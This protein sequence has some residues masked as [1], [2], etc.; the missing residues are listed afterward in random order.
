M[1]VEIPKNAANEP[2]EQTAD[3]KHAAS[4]G[5]T[6]VASKVSETGH[7]E[8]V[9]DGAAEQTVD[10]PGQ[11]EE[12]RSEAAN[13]NLNDKSKDDITRLNLALDN[14]STTIHSDASFFACAENKE[15]SFGK[16]L[17]EIQAFLRNSITTS[18]VGNSCYYVCGVP[19]IGKTSGVLWSV[20]KV[21]KD[22]AAEKCVIAGP[23]DDSED[24]DDVAKPVLCHV[25]A[26]H[27]T[28]V[29][30]TFE[31]IL[32]QIGQVVGVKGKVD[33]I[34]K[35]GKIH[36]IVVMDEIENL[37]AK[38]PKKSFP[39]SESEESLEKLIEMA[40]DDDVH[41][42]LI[43]ISNSVGDEKFAR[44]DG[45][46]AVRHNRRRLR[47]R[48]GYNGSHFSFFCSFARSHLEPIRKMI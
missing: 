47:Y 19:G 35:R 25:N 15:S 33:N 27:F 44:I 16:K 41:L 5:N 37:L 40:N 42:T 11:V 3:S 26:T 4:D 29:N 17:N 1:D 31:A 39:A 28:A 48:V 43:G 6:D 20:E 21:I 45:L 18:D 2:E 36:A 24:M 23:G 38:N 12:A 14:L 22:L 8:K 10:V 13:E 32:K 9:A 7:S 34:L 46:K 30:K